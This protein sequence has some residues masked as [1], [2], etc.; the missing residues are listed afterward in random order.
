[1]DVHIPVAITESLRR[2]GIDVL[3]SQEDR[4][5]EATDEA[6][7]QRAVELGRVLF[8]QDRDLLRIAH[9]WQSLQEPFPGLV[10]ARQKGMSIG[11]CIEDLTLIAECV[12]ADELANQV[13]FLPL[14]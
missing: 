5:H 8:S 10:F 13:V 1:M 11:Q 3:T 12:G 2:R 6:L 9:Q 14:T 4:T 7:L